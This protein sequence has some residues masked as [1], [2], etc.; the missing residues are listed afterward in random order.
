MHQYMARTCS[1]FEEYIFDI[2]E[3]TCVTKDVYCRN[4]GKAEARDKIGNNNDCVSYEEQCNNNR[5]VDRGGGKFD[6][7]RWDGNSCVFDYERTNWIN[8]S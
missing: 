8:P 5:E 1:G 7:Y 4:R 3:N 6:V 2:M